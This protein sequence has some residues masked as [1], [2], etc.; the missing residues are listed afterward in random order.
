MRKNVVF[1]VFIVLSL[2]NISSS[3]TK[4]VLG[5]EDKEEGG[6]P[7]ISNFIFGV[8]LSY[9]QQVEDHGGI[10]KEDNELVDPYQLFKKK[11]A[12]MVRLR[13]W[14]N[15]DWVKD[16]YGEE[17]IIYSG[18]EEVASN[19]KRAKENNL[20]VNLDFHYSDV[21]ADP[22]HQDV[23][24]AW[25]DI[26][27]IDVLVDSVYNYTYQVL[28]TLHKRDLLPQMVQIG[29]ETNCGMMLTNTPNT[30][31]NLSICEGNWENFGKV[32]NAGINAVRA[33][34]KMSGENTQIV[35]HI[36]DP[37]NLD[38]WFSDV[39]SKGMVTD[40]DIAGFSFYNLWHTDISFSALPGVVSAFIEK[41][42]KDVIVLETAYPFTTESNDAYNN[43][44][45]GEGPITNYPFTIEGQKKFM[46][47]LTQNMINAGAIG[48]MYWEPAWITSELTDLWGTGSSWENCAVF[49]F[50]GNATDAINYLNHEYTFE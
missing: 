40:F 19:I 22:G 17:T 44:Y 33:I 36:A 27:D 2:V 1:I 5:G 25:K 18:F 26:V 20:A 6:K 47:D 43:I 9:I 10:Y 8:D 4:D 38:W 34:D 24:K 35:L 3:C 31:P 48:V 41:T 50:S 39:M 49:D 28:H 45:G 42:N 15:P 23:P 30:F 11:G 7:E 13:L 37:I 29:N 16:I 32:L 12:N 21:W 14:H 46:I